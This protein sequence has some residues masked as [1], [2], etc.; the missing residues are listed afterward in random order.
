[1]IKVTHLSP[2]F[3][4]QSEEQFLFWFSTA[5]FVEYRLSEFGW[6]TMLLRNDINMD[7]KIENSPSW[8]DSVVCCWSVM[9]WEEESNFD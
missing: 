9:M 5:E 1:M 8:R 3:K 6:R 2:F 7:L 4:S